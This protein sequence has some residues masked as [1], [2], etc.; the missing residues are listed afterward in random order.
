MSICWRTWKA[1]VVG[2][3]RRP[4]SPWPPAEGARRDGSAGISMASAR[5]S[6]EPGQ[7]R[8]HR[9][10]RADRR[11]RKEGGCRKE[12]R[13]DRCSTADRDPVRRRRRGGRGHC[14]RRRRQRRDRRRRLDARGLHALTPAGRPGPRDVEEETD[15]CS[16]EDTDNPDRRAGGRCPSGDV[17][18]TP[19]PPAWGASIA[20]ARRPHRHRRRRP[21][22]RHRRRLGRR[23][24]AARPAAPRGCPTA[25]RPRRRARAPPCRSARTRRTT[26]TGA[27]GAAARRRLRICFRPAPPR[28]GPPRTC[29][30]R[31]E[32]E[33]RRAELRTNASSSDLHL[34]RARVTVLRL[35]GGRLEDDPLEAG[36]DVRVRVTRPR[37]APRDERVQDLQIVERAPHPGARR[38]LPEHHPHGEH[39]GPPIDRLAGG[40]LRGHEGDLPLEHAA[41]RVVRRAERLRDAE[42]DHLD[43]PVVGQEEVVRAHVPVH[44]VHRRP[45]ELRRVVGVLQALEHLPEDVELVVQRHRRALPHA[46][47]E[48]PVERLA[49]EEL[50]REEVPALGGYRPNHLHRFRCH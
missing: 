5:P 37:D 23:G 25:S 11:Q 46:P 50:H 10:W 13:R 36:V 38:R 47:R 20:A 27:C 28:T 30:G 17:R 32:A 15:G 49:V 42:V 24:C 45:V 48:R 21:V 43:L 35:H 22:L 39:V 1:D 31:A 12:R 26:S 2:R 19:C 41:P 8:A 7:R 40:L 9:R 44:E 18:R 14:R 3:Q 16:Q 29:R 33:R 6:V 34:R 4:R